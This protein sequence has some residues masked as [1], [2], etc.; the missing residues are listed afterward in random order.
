MPRIV[1]AEPAL[2]TVLELLVPR[3]LNG[4]ELRFVRRFGI[5]VEIVERHD[6][7]TKIGEPDRQ[8]IDARIFFHQGD[9]NVFR[10]GPLHQTTSSTFGR[11]DLPSWIPPPSC[12]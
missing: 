2:L 3:H 10:I 11:S 12:T 7:L 1:T 5:V 6:A 8:R 4:L 9:A